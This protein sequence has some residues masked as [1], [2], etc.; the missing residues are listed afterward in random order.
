MENYEQ[1]YG[2]IE[3]VLFENE[4]NGYAVLKVKTWDGEQAVVTGCFPNPICGEEIEADGCWAEHKTYGRQFQSERFE[5]HL[6]TD[7]HSIFQFLSNGAIKGIG[8]ATASLIVNQYKSDSL[9][10]LAE[11]PEKIA[12]IR[13]ISLKKALDWSE[14]YKKTTFLRRLMEYLGNT[15]I[16]PFVAMNLYKFYGNEC[17]NVIKKNPYIL[18]ENGIGCNFR[19][20]DLLARTE[21]TEYD[22]PN[23]I[24]A[25]IIFELKHNL[26][27]GHCFIPKNLLIDATSKLI[28]VE[29]Q[30]IEKNLEEIIESGIV[31]CDTLKNIEAVYLPELHEAEC[32]CAKRLSEIQNNILVITGRPGTGKSTMIKEIINR[33]DK[34]GVKYILAAPTGRAA[35][36]MEELTGCEAVTIH[37]L[38]GA[39][40]SDDGETT[41]FGKDDDDKLDCGALILDECSMV[42][43]MLFEAVLKALP[44]KA[45]LI[46]VGDADQLPPVGPGNVFK[47][48]IASE[49]FETKVLTK[50]HRQSAES[51][52][53]SN[54]NMIINGEYPDFGANSGDFFR[55]KRLESGSTVDTICELYSKRLP[56]KMNI[57]VKDIQV[58]SP[59]RKGELGTVN[60]NRALQEVLN[61]PSE[62]K[63]E[64]MFGERIFR[65][66]DRVM[67]IRNNY[68]VTWH[69]EDLKSVGSGI[70]NGD[71]GCIKKIDKENEFLTIDFDGHIAAYSFQS[72][73]ELEHA[74]ACT[75]HKSQGSEYKAVILSLS[76]S[77]KLLLTRD[78]LYTAVTRA[79]ELLV[80][81]GD[82]SVAREMIDNAKRANRYSFLRYRICS[83]C[84]KTGGNE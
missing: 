23:R 13:G 11:N 75:V 6:P 82:D 32:Y 18:A 49:A 43:I 35:K 74:W 69:T 26:N 34:S 42:D 20:A 40:L 58:L 81:V 60:L 19:E 61:P 17:F 21:G 83:C 36:R 57:D 25:A 56:Q 48:I 5:R 66:G 27:N 63:Q 29:Y 1:I 71:I 68:D 4:E 64:R 84:E 65:E 79:R 39:S 77:S 2:T 15:G 33:F 78:I 50:I 44:D 55:L 59:T 53:I 3:A 38:L 72:L 67:Q 46:L 30:I 73:N 16:K 70:F 52:I 22:D 7:E 28:G 9:E 31:E 76:P 80:M 51:R 47:A 41:I 12:E 62:D 24:N 10:I 45:R 14:S 37:R 54:A 8:P